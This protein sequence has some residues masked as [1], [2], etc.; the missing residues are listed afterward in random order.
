M[1]FGVV[2]FWLELPGMLI[3]ANATGGG[4]Y[5]SC[6]MQDGRVDTDEDVSMSDQKR[7]FDD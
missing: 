2:M 1:K 4:G 7:T 5:T 3:A 6:A